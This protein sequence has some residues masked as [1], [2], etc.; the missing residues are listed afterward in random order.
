MKLSKETRSGRAKKG[1]QFHLQNLINNNPYLLNRLILDASSTLRNAISGTIKWVSP[2]EKENYLE[3]QD[4]EFLEAIGYPQLNKDLSKFWPEGGPVW[5]ALAIFPLK[6]ENRNG[7]ILLEA[8]SHIKELESS[9][10]SAQGKSR[11]NIIRTFEGIQKVIGITLNK[12]WLDKYYQYA[13][14]LAHLYFLSI[15]QKI[16]TWLIFLYFINDVEQ[17]GPINEGKWLGVIDEVKKTLGLPAR[18]I[19]SDNII[20]VFI[21]LNKL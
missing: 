7:V 3:Y 9:G 18:H 21:D 5:D 8:K 14:R 2:I 13:N 17:S 15:V 1:S 20:N 12:N 10:C 16:P 11:E 19:L 4:A 6:A